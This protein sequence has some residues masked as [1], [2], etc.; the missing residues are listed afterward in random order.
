[1][2]TTTLNETYLSRQPVLDLQQELVGYELQLQS[3][4]ILM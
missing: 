2:N 4:G 3:A 1:M